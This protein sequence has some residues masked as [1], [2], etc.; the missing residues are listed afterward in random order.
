[1]SKGTFDR[2][3]HRFGL[4]GIL[5][6]A[7]FVLLTP[8]L[9]RVADGSP[10]TPGHLSYQALLSSDLLWQGHI[11]YDPVHDAYVVPTPHSLL[12]SMMN[13]FGVQWLL[14]MLIMLLLLC[15]LYWL[16]RKIIREPA[17]LL[18]TLVVFLLSPSVVSLGTW[19]S[20]VSLATLFVAISALSFQRSLPLA[21]F[22]LFL[23]SITSFPI[24]ILAVIIGVL[25]FLYKRNFSSMAW[26]GGAGM[27][28]VLWFYL[29]S[30]S[31]PP[32]FSFGLR[33]NTLFELGNYQGISVMIILLAAF[34]I[35]SHFLHKKFL[36]GASGALI[37]SLAFVVP[38]FALIATIFLSALAA[39]GL[40]TLVFHGWKLD[41]L[42]QASIVLVFCMLLFTFLVAIQGRVDD[43]PDGAFSK[44]MAD[45]AYQRRPGAVLSTPESAAMIEYFSGRKSTLTLSSSAEDV[46]LGLYSR[47]ADEVYSFLEST[48]TSYI[49]LTSDMV[50]DDFD[51]SDEGILFLLENT[52]RF[53]PIS[54]NALA[55]T[56]YYIPRTPSPLAKKVS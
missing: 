4:F 3:I 41:L 48:N 20:T 42:R 16:L 18:T 25:F 39:H 12:L 1:M 10:I 19:H 34:G 33:S 6:L 30:K 13:F 8:L 52:Q 49:F 17:I 24:G 36:I 27:L 35:S 53:V 7:V 46:A 9:L 56:W 5:L 40:F 15:V 51:R 2:N 37:S 43:Q 50:Q 38:E 29:W 44:A 47:N 28:S 21:S 26:I 31:L 54:K 11:G 14:P 23:A 45:L 22:C 55:T 32:L